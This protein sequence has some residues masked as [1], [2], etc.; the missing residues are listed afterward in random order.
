MKNKLNISLGILNR[1]Y[2]ALLSALALLLMYKGGFKT[3]TW[4][5]ALIGS[6]LFILTLYRILEVKRKTRRPSALSLKERL[7]T[8]LLIALCFQLLFE[9]AG[10]ELFPLLYLASP[11]LFVYLGW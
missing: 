6:F 1:I 10:R 2:V 11:F 3:A 8:G 7:E 4:Y 5:S 9:I